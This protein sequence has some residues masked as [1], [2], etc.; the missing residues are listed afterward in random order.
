[1]LV[2]LLSGIGKGLL[3]GSGKSEKKKDGGALA[4][5]MFDRK[6]KE[7]EDKREK[8]KEPLTIIKREKVSYPKLFTDIKEVDVEVEESP[9]S[10]SVDNLQ[11]AVA[12]LLSA[13]QESVDV[14]KKGEKDKQKVDKKKEK[15]K[16]GIGLLDG[17]K[18]KAFDFLDMVKRFFL[19]T[20]VGGIVTAIAKNIGIIVEAIRTTIE[21]VQEV[22]DFMNKYL[23]QPLGK[24]FTFIVGPIAEQIAK[25]MG[26]PS[27]EAEMNSIGENMKE[28]AKQI[29]IIG[30]L[31][32]GFEDLIGDKFSDVGAGGGAGGPS[33]QY[34]SAQAGG[35]VASGGIKMGSKAKQQAASAGFGESEFTLFRDTVAQ[36]ESGGEYDL[37]GGSG[38]MYSG[39]YQMGAAAR[40]DAARY[41]GETYEGDTPEAR[42]KF[43]N[44]PEMQE[45]YFAAYTRANHEYL[46]RGSA[47]YR[48]L[49]KEEKLQALGYAHNLGWSAAAAWL[50]RGRTGSG[51][52]GF[53]T[54]SDMFA[55]NIRKAQ[56][57]SRTGKLDAPTLTGG[58][59]GGMSGPSYDTGLKTGPS[60]YIGGSADYHIDAQFMKS[61][62]MDQKVAMVDQMARGYEAK[63][64]QM[65]FSNTG[66]RQ[67]VWNPNASHQDKVRLLQ[68]AFAAHSHSR[69]SDRNSI[70]FYAIRKGSTDLYDK[71]GEGAPILAPKIQ[72]GSATY[73]SGGG[74]GNYVEIKDKNGRVLFRT[75]HGD[76]RFGRSSGTVPLSSQIQKP[77]GADK[78][79]EISKSASYDS[80]NTVAFVPVPQQSGG[81]GSV[82][83]SDGSAPSSSKPTYAETAKQWTAA[84]IASHMYKA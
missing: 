29:P 68:R 55:Q 67:E 20:I 49:S 7:K 22:F 10:K 14:K 63:G 27:E 42:Q 50:S 43:R 71:S 45:R 74:Y 57:L 11:K 2:G 1:M 15:K 38:N 59:G 48:S 82:N 23:F 33:Y 64:L 83:S 17:I 56:E 61:V 39:R 75:G 26:V 13:A 53:G 4:K 66:V 52:D 40:Q 36:I 28:I 60:Q 25:I 18:T 44:D 72:G 5:S 51:E 12:G 84:K 19:F 16:S 78:P 9:V 31:V 21:K 79:K 37:Q 24:A 41:L 76:T 35:L 8:E 32:R 54:K 58:G 47:E 81:S 3:S 73:A 77:K 69:Y 30:D 65:V 80:K 34:D 62:P 46:M 6:K 70:D